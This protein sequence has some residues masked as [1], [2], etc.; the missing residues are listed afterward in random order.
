MVCMWYVCGLC[1]CVVCV[2]CACVCGVCMICAVCMS[3]LGPITT[4]IIPMALRLVGDSMMC[5][6]GSHLR[7]WR[8][9]LESWPCLLGAL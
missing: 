9:E 7:T 5:E 3:E 8:P 4:W 2:E 1:M 6:E